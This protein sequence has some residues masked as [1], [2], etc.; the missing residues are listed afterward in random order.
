M[1]CIQ[2]NKFH[3]CQPSDSPFLYLQTASWKWIFHLLI[4]Q[5]IGF[6]ATGWIKWHVWTYIH[7][8]VKQKCPCSTCKLH[9]S[10]TL[11]ENF[12]RHVIKIEFLNLFLQMTLDSC[13]GCATYEWLTQQ[14]SSSSLCKQR[15]R[16]HMAINNCF[17]G[18]SRLSA[19]SGMSWMMAWISKSSSFP[20]IIWTAH[21]CIASNCRLPM[22]VM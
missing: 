15:D 10:K 8:N 6:Y 21:H 3:W 18:L 2:C 14:L 16:S 1:S 20:K 4:N 9:H 17:I 22:S 5:L 7:Q 12:T 19:S 13:C 11:I